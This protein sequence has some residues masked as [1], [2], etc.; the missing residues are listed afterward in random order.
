VGHP[1]THDLKSVIKLNLIAN[2]P[3]T[4]EASL[5]I[6]KGETTRQ[7]P[8]PVVSDYVAVPP[9][10]VST[11]KFVT[12]F[13]DLFFINK[14]PFFVTVSDHIK[15]TSTE[16]IANRKVKQHVLASQHVQAVY[17]ARD[18]RVKSMLMDG[19]FVPLKHDLATA[20]IVLNTTSAN[21]HVPK[22]EIV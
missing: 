7:S 18:F 14:V 12:L 2:C 16:H 13:G 20:G 15:F 1:S 19:E 9:S 5:P 6:L 4:A 17:A 21:E 11:N 3:V 10:I 22:I 8:L